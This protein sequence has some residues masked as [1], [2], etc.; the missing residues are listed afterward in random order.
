MGYLNRLH[1]HNQSVVIRAL[2]QPVV[3]DSIHVDGRRVVNIH[4]SSWHEYWDGCESLPQSL[5]RLRASWTEFIQHGHSPSYRAPY[6]HAY[7]RLLEDA[8]AA[9]CRDEID[10]SFFAKV[11]GFETFAITGDQEQPVAGVFNARNP[12]YLL[13]RIRQPQAPEDPKFLP[14]ICLPR[15]IDDGSG[16]F[17]HYRR[18]GI[19]ESRRTELFVYP[20]SELRSCSSACRLISELFAA[21][22]PVNDPWVNERSQL[23]FEG[24]FSD[25]IACFAGQHVQLLDVAC[26]SAKLTTSL[27]RR[28]SARH[29]TSFDLTLVDVVRA[30]RSMA[31]T[32][33][34]CPGTFGN[35]VFHHE[36][37]FD[38]I[39]NADPA[40]L[41]HFDVI[42]ML[43]AYDLFADI[44]IERLSWHE[45]AA[46]AY[47][48]HGT[49]LARDVT[50]TAELLNQHRLDE[51]QHRLR[52][53]VYRGGELF[54][55]FSLSEYFRAIYTLLTHEIPSDDGVV[56]APIRRFDESSLILA[57]GD[58][59]IEKLLTLGTQVLFEDSQL[60]A[61]RL[62]RH[63]AKFGVSRCFVKDMRFRRGGRGTHVS[64]V[65]RQEALP[66][67]RSIPCANSVSPATET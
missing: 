32:I 66:P 67:C 44:R 48:D 13:S 63:I 31:D 1:R 28:A 10:A 33:I 60:S 58:S 8:L 26:G 15:E 43:R 3:F 53:S 54:H 52:R 55:Q 14:V 56:Y 30:S 39:D 59:V 50:R 62:R 12:V 19:L 41:P 49:V 61:D 6:V 16:L 25:V 23:L 37:F 24:A 11:V 64:I 7:F 9:F 65:G 36:D 22:T 35:V 45:A 42:L 57:S 21:L 5:A 27:C 51:I 20:P 18:I 4:V 40:S 46:L 47:R 29:G 34:R 2:R 38:W 17:C